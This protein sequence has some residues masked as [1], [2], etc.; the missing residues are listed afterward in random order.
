M[1]V[2][3]SFLS[4]SE[5]KH[6]L[7]QT[8]TFEK[9]ARAIHGEKRKMCKIKHHFD[10]LNL[11]IKQKLEHFQHHPDV[12][13][14]RIHDCSIIWTEPG[15]K[16]QD[17]HMDALKRFA[18][19]NIILNS[20]IA[21]EFL[22]VPFNSNDQDKNVMTN[23]FDYHLC[24]A[25]S[26]EKLIPLNM[27][28][29]DAVFFWSNMIHRG[30]SMPLEMKEPRIS[31][32]MTFPLKTQGKITTDFAFPNWAWID[33]HFI[34]THR[35]LR[36]TL[37]IDFIIRHDLLHLY[38]KDWHGENIHQ[39]VEDQIKNREKFISL[40]PQEAH[41]FLVQWKTNDEFFLAKVTTEKNK[42]CI[43]YYPTSKYPKTTVENVDMDRWNNI[44][45]IP[46]DTKEAVD[47]YCGYSFVPI[48]QYMELKP[49][50]SKKWIVYPFSHLCLKTEEIVIPFI[51]PSSSCSS[52]FVHPKLQILEE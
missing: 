13:F 43:L 2:W 27:K 22:D 36:P 17:W 11:N 1:Q 19:L 10:A 3:Q 9:H 35:L 46:I 50:L 6:I 12:D 39:L 5:K 42:K 31:L 20:D 18:V 23:T 52:I 7:S 48:P 32:Y 33:A 14:D 4:E 15:A 24:W 21:T 47:K 49:S 16:C 45:K 51:V 26:S 28:K 34:Q 41:L 30:P 37:Q 40:F 38:P 44:T 29:G 8:L 25:L